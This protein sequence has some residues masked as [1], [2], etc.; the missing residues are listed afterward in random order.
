VYTYNQLSRFEYDELSAE[1]TRLSEEKI[2]DTSDKN[3][4]YHSSGWI[5]FK[6]SAYQSSNVSSIVA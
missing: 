5:G 4:V 3:Y 2:L 1:N 6:P